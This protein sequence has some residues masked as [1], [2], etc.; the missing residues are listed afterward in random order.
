MYTHRIRSCIS[1][2]YKS[3]TSQSNFLTKAGIVPTNFFLR[4]SRQGMNTSNG[5][6]PTSPREDPFHV[7]K[8]PA[9]KTV[10]FSVSFILSHVP[11]LCSSAI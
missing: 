8:G 1:T 6:E 10:V 2:I 4:R 5:G 9:M 11:D 7:R 3:V